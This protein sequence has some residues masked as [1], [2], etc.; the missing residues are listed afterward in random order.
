V[1]DAGMTLHFLSREFQENEGMLIT[2]Q[3]YAWYGSIIEA[4]AYGAT[5]IAVIL[6]FRRSQHKK[7]MA[8]LRESVRSEYFTQNVEL[9]TT[10]QPANGKR[11]M[12][13]AASPQL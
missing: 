1:Y 13:V 9:G 7:K 8:K 11:Y 5:F 12:P 6:V 2:K 3:T 4:I 10:Y